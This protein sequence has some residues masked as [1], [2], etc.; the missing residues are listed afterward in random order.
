VSG[1]RGI[2]LLKREE[3]F[4]QI[5]GDCNPEKPHG[6]RKL[7]KREERIELGEGKRTI[8]LGDTGIG[9]PSSGRRDQCGEKKTGTVAGKKKKGFQR[10]FSRSAS[11][12]RHHR[13]LNCDGKLKGEKVHLD[14][15]QK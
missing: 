9:E 5:S 8:E 4:L 14:N 1:E 10:L 12:Q 2:N 13:P 11:V 3:S 7:R 15:S 6:Q